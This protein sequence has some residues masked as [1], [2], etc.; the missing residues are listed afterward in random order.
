[1]TE[2]NKCN[3]LIDEGFSLITVKSDKIPNISWKEF[4]TN[5]M[6]K[7][8]FKKVYELESTEGVGIVTGF[9]YL[10]CIDV[11]LYLRVN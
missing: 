6:D 9:D 11:P 3:R 4:M 2:I 8:S 5:P 10:E 7:E 1:M